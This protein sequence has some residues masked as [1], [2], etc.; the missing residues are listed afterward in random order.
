MNGQSVVKRYASA[1]YESARESGLLEALEEDLKILDR[2][3]REAPDIRSYCLEPS[4]SPKR[5]RIFVETAFLP[6]LSGLTAR[7]VEQLLAN[8]RLEALPYLPEAC[9]EIGDADRGITAVR[10]ESAAEPDADTKKQIRSHLEQR[11]GGKIR[12]EWRIRPELQGGFTLEWNRRFAD[13]SLRGRFRR[14]R[15]VLQRNLS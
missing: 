15:R 9:R 10:I 3:F 12:T 6:F 2:L 8:Q 5:N 11:I 1:L 7:A 14:L 13:L 4:S